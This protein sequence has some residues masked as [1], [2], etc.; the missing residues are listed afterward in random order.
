MVKETLPN[1][2]KITSITEMG[3][4]LMELTI[5]SN[6][7]HKPDYIRADLVDRL[8]EAVEGYWGSRNEYSEVDAAIELIRGDKT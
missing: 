6:P 4:S 1:Q 3:G 7:K 8:I 5:S 2:L